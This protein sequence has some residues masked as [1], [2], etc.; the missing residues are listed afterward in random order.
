MVPVV[1]PHFFDPSQDHSES[2]AVMPVSIAAQMASVTFLCSH[3]HSS[4]SGSHQ[5]GALK[6]PPWYEQEPATVISS[7]QPQSFVTEQKF[8]DLSSRHSDS[9]RLRHSPQ[10]PSV[11]S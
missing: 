6:T 8:A 11:S 5:L 9:V 7:T 3:C 1:Y 4:V 10:P 2:I